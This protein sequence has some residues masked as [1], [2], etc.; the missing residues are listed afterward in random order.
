[1]A[2]L[3]ARLAKELGV[4]KRRRRR[5]KPITCASNQRS[6][7]PAPSPPPAT[8][9]A[10]SR[11]PGGQIWAHDHNRSACT[12]R[13]RARPR[14]A[15]RPTS[16]ADKQAPEIIRNRRQQMQSSSYLLTSP[17]DDY[18]ELDFGLGRGRA[19]LTGRRGLAHKSRRL[20]RR[21]ILARACERRRRRRPSGPLG[22]C[23][24]GPAADFGQ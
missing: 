18:D 15:P 13:A 20:G 5:N 9:G 24:P 11:P 21:K 1:V 16:A 2:N 7:R 14:P 6:G 12:S 10:R 4:A 3:G 17:N 23:A 19:E 8:G 22:C